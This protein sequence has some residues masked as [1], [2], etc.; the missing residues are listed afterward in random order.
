[1][2]LAYIHAR[3]ATSAILFLA[4]MAL[5]AFRQVY[6]KQGLTGSYWGALVIAE[7][8]VLFESALGLILYYGGDRSLYWAHWLYG[9]VLL[10]TL[11]GIYIYTK[12]KAEHPEV[13]L[14]GVGFLIMVVFVLRLIVTGGK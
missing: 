6:F 3:L 1:M 7:I 10:L 4:F 13:I 11:P 12:G 2:T 8:L 5:W 14:Y 9:A